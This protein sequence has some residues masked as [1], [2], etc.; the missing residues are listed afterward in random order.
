MNVLH[1]LCKCKYLSL[2]NK[3]HA[4]A[5]L[6]LRTSSYP[7]LHRLLWEVWFV[8][9]LWWLR[10][11]ISTT[12]FFSSPRGVSKWIKGFWKLCDCQMDQDV[13]QLSVGQVTKR[14]ARIAMSL[15]GVVLAFIR[16]HLSSCQ[17][18]GW[19]TN[20]QWAVTPIGDLFENSKK[21]SIHYLVAQV[22]LFW[23][24]ENEF[25]V[26]KYDKYHTS[27][28]LFTI[29]WWDHTPFVKNVPH[30]VHLVNW[31]KNHYGGW[32]DGVIQF[33]KRL[34]IM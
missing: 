28:V 17:R 14:C 29:I 8:R 23:T 3:E 11:T 19:A 21:P 31:H 22:E 2:F 7:K 27:L 9:K 10:L 12:N 15:Q 34:Q 32:E 4:S 1:L 20:K 30:L 26:N 18:W 16:C 6:S 24:K 33:Q 25:V 13:H 5:I